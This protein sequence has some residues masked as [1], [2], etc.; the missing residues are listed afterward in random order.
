MGTDGQQPSS[1]RLPEVK[2]ET[3]KSEMLKQDDQFTA[4]SGA[5]NKT[6]LLTKPNYS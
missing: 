2:Q 3:L 4:T 1:I 5:V 6:A